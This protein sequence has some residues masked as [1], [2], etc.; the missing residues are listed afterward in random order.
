MKI[1]QEDFCGFIRTGYMTE[2]AMGGR[3]RLSNSR[4][5]EN[6]K[7]FSRP[8]CIGHLGLCLGPPVHKGPTIEKIVHLNK[9]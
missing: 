7:A 4:S 6:V 8:L 1:E 3:G 2:R 5:R 9:F